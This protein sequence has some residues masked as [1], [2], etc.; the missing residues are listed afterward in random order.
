[1]VSREQEDFSAES[2]NARKKAWKEEQCETH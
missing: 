1:M 2:G